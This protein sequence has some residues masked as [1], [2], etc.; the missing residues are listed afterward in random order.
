MADFKTHITTSSMLGIAYGAAGYFMYDISLPHCIVAGTLCSV[1]GMLPDLDSESGVPLREM[2]SFV[3]VLA[4]MLML[5]RFNNF[6]WTPET[7]V[8]VAVLLYLG[9]RFGI[10]S[11]FRRF[12]RHRGMWHSIPAALIAGMLT[13]LLALSPEIE[14]RA[15]KGWAVVLGFLSHLL[16]DEIYSIDLYGRQLLKS[17]AGTAMKLYDSRMLPNILSYVAV[18]GLGYLV[19][20]DRGIVEEFPM[21]QLADKLHNLTEKIERTSELIAPRR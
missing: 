20:V 4:P 5:R 6:G 8:F 7:M 9:I 15:F 3:A 18:I 10:G 17:S 11:L 2:L 12:T 21:S 14:I 1:A 19:L 13:Y 16:L